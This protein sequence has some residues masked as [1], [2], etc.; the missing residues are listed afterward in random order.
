MLKESIVVFCKSEDRDAFQAVLDSQYVVLFTESEE[1]TW[2]TLDTNNTPAAVLI[3]TPLQSRDNY[4]FAQEIKNDIRYQDTPILFVCNDP[5]PEQKT[6]PYDNRKFPRL[7]RPLNLTSVLQ[8]IQRQVMK[9]Q[10]ETELKEYTTVDPLTELLKRDHFTIAAEKQIDI[11]K[12]KAKKI[13]FAMLALDDYSAICQKYSKVYSDQILKEF[14][15]ICKKHLR[16]YDLLARYQEHR[17]VASFYD[18]AKEQALQVIRRI[19]DE[20]AAKVFLC[21]SDEVKTTCSSGVA[22]ILELSSENPESILPDTLT[23]A[24]QRLEIA[25]H[26]GGNSIVS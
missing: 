26:K 1:H 18:C 8:E 25:T 9:N 20:V 4:S 22:E 23:I 24:Y 7:Y 10:A 3:D 5:K 6:V 2:H 12:E 13:S 16:P 17:L 21:N 15:D 14:A 19:S 11:V